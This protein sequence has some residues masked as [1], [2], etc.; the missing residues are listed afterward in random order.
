MLI[1]YLK[2]ASAARS[3]A[4][5]GACVV[6]NS[7]SS[8]L[9]INCDVVTTFMQLHWM[10]FLSLYHPLWWH[11]CMHCLTG[12]TEYTPWPILC[13]RGSSHYGWLATEKVPQ[14][15][16]WGWL[17]VDGEGSHDGIPQLHAFN[18]TNQ[19]W[20]SPYGWWDSATAEAFVTSHWV[21]TWA[22]L[23]VCSWEPMLSATSRCQCLRCWDCHLFLHG[24][25]WVCPQGCVAT[26]WG[27]LWHQWQRS[28]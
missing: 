21:V 18:F 11:C 10:A 28:H 19:L 24:W 27:P 20:K 3:A 7:L 8:W 6:V 15:E 4:S 16:P 23:L 13:S 12:Y 1:S 2:A 25:Q 22:W 5:E 26:P 14:V 9:C 17:A